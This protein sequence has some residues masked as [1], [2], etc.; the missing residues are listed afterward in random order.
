MVRL[1]IAEP[2]RLVRLTFDGTNVDEF[3]RTFPEANYVNT[4]P[5][6]GGGYFTLG[7]PSGR[8]KIVPGTQLQRIGGKYTVRGGNGY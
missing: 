2:A 7:L 3:K 8:V 6:N 5:C 4:G 1:T